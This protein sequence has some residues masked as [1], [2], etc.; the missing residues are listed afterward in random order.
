MIDFNKLIFD[1]YIKTLQFNFKPNNQLYKSNF[2][3]YNQLV[4]YKP[5]FFK[6]V[7][8]LPY[9]IRVII[10]TLFKKKLQKRL[11]PLFVFDYPLNFTL[12]NLSIVLEILINNLI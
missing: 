11:I 6:I 2:L 9:E 10:F 7:F 12:L 3:K 8:L 5:N 1:D 4:L